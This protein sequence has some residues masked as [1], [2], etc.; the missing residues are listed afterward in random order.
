[1]KRGRKSIHPGR[2]LT[3]REAHQREEARYPGLNARRCAEYRARRKL[4]ALNRSTIQSE[5]SLRL[6]ALQ[7]ETQNATQ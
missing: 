5:A 7:Q 1:M 6:A 4:K 3:K 2:S